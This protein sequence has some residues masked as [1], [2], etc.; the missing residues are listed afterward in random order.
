MK[1]R[2][3]MSA[4][5]LATC[6]V[7]TA[8]CGKKSSGSTN[9]AAPATRELTPQ[10]KVASDFFKA[11]VAGDVET[12]MKFVSMSDEAK[13]RLAKTIRGWAEWKKGVTGRNKEFV[14]MVESA[15][16]GKSTSKGDAVVITLVYQ[17]GGR[18]SER[19]AFILKQIGGKWLITEYDIMR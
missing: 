15:K 8:G 19:D 6:L 14:T 2:M 12:A 5:L 13:A 4:L 1:F 7:F 3:L 9:A 11:Y 17:S 18:S 16:I 10:E